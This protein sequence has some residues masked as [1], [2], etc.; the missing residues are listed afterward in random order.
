MRKKKNRRNLLDN[1][2]Y[3]RNL[4]DEKKQQGEYD[5]KNF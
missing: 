3:R 1:R 4:T 5:K 2:N